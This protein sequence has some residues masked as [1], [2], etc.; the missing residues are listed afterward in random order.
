[1]VGRSTT[2]GGNVT[3]SCG[4]R[5]PAWLI[6]ARSGAQQFRRRC[7]QSRERWS[8]RAGLPSLPHF[9]HAFL[10]TRQDGMV[11]LQAPSNR[12]LGSSPC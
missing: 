11:D 7:E 3:H 5:R 12:G 9:T 4:L 8:V 2:G 1:V 6:S 10:W